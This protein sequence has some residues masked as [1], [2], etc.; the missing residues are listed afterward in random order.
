MEHTT[1]TQAGERT[2]EYLDDLREQEEIAQG[3]RDYRREIMLDDCSTAYLEGEIA[4]REFVQQELQRR[5]Y[6]GELEATDADGV[7]TM[8]S[9]DSYWK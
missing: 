4:R 3:E 7:E 1:T 6:R 2:Q 8:Q 5:I 9:Q